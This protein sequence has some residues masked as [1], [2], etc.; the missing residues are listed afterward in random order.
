VAI[1]KRIEERALKKLKR[2]ERK[3]ETLRPLL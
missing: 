3:E 1:E 2:L